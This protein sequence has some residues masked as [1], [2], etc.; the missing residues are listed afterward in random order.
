[1]ELNSEDENG[2][3]DAEDWL[4]SSISSFN[5]EFENRLGIGLL[6]LKRYDH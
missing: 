4:S 3:E 6:L 5:S 2:D 1:M